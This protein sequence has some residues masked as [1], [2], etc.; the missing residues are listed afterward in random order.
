MTNHFYIDKP[1]S[2][3]FENSEILN[4]ESADGQRMKR[5][6]FVL[7]A[8]YG[9]YLGIKHP[10]EYPY[11]NGS[12]IFVM[13]QLDDD[14]LAI[15]Y[16]IAISDTKDVGIIMDNVEVANITMQYANAGLFYLKD[17]E[18]NSPLNK[19]LSSFRIIIKEVFDEFYGDQK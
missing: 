6:E 10:F 5:D 8:A 1:L 16:S 4:S 13:N 9:F 11:S 15:L 12:D 7:L 19:K 18:N 2:H 17:L 3:F 14:Q